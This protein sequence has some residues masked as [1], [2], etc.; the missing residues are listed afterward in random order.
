MNLR[1][2]QGI[3]LQLSRRVCDLG[4]REARGRRWSRFLVLLP[5]PSHRWWR[6]CLSRRAG[7]VSVSNK[8]QLQVCGALYSDLAEWIRLCDGMLE[9]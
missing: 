2:Q 5:S 1:P 6:T 8:T 3:Q 7:W 4:C 9:P